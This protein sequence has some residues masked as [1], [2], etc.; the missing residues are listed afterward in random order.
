MERDILAGIFPSDSL[1]PSVR[2]LAVEFSINPNTIQ[3]AYT[4]LEHRGITY[5]VPGV[6]RY[7]TKDAA[8]IIRKNMLGSKTELYTA[9]T[10]LKLAGFSL[11]EIVETV[12][13]IYKEEDI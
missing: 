8:S 2:S 11:D 12:T 7:V 1:I 6:G 3:K 10:N 5:S 13:K 4:E 9:V